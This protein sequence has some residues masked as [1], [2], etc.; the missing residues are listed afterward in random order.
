MKRKVLLCCAV[1]A[2]FVAIIAVCML[3]QANAADGRVVRVK[4]GDTLA[5]LLDGKQVSVRLYGIDAPEKK[6]PFGQAAR[7][8]A[9]SLVAGKDVAVDELAIDRYG[10]TVAMVTV[11]GVNLQEK[12]LSA[13]YVW[14]YDGYCHRPECPGWRGL[15]SEAQAAKKGL[16]LDAAPT[17]PWLYRNGKHLNNG[18]Q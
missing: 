4:D 3:Q 8:Y 7:E 2:W 16:W 15:Q 17:P 9:A 1:V 5:V 14:V 18:A 13:G 10:R 12:M 11:G 6:Q